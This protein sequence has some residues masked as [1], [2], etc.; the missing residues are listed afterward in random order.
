MVCREG[1]VW[2]FFHSYHSKCCCYCCND[3]EQNWI[4]SLMNRTWY[5]GM[6][7]YNTVNTLLCVFLCVPIER[8]GIVDRITGLERFEI[9]QTESDEPALG[10]QT[11]LNTTLTQPVWFH[12]LP[13]REAW[14][15]ARLGEGDQLPCQGHKLHCDRSS[16]GAGSGIQG[17]C[18]QWCWARQTEQGHTS[19]HCQRSHL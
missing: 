12:R 17:S 7:P 2:N 9:L 3:N 13:G 14:E 11:L 15:G 5:M 1:T 10:F 18:Y 16:G 19:A 4:Y 6:L 8:V